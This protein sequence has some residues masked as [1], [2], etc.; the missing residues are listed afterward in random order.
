[1][2][3]S[4]Q[5]SRYSDSIKLFKTKQFLKLFSNLFKICFK[6]ISYFISDFTH[7]QH[8]HHQHGDTTNNH[9]HHGPGHGTHHNTASRGQHGTNQ[10]NS[11]FKNVFKIDSKQTP[12]HPSLD[13]FN[14]DGSSK[15][16][17]NSLD[18]EQNQIDPSSDVRSK[19]NIAFNGNGKLTTNRNQEKLTIV[20]GI[21]QDISKGQN[22]HPK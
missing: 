15:T 16:K 6:N 9:H 7:Q 17:T 20:H 10:N 2:F 19:R 3:V 1:M 12:T 22:K 18:T 11:K 14:L 4:G 13:G 21:V 8:H 5:C